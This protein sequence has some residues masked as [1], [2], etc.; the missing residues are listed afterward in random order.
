MQ[1]W[2]IARL[3]AQR[4]ARAEGADRAVHEPRVALPELGA[5]E[6][7]PLCRSRPEA[8]DERIGAVG[9]LEHDLAAPIG[10]EVDGERALAGVRGEE[11]RAFSV[12]K[13]RPPGAGVVPGKRLHLDDVGPERGEQLCRSRARE[14]GR[15]VDDLGAD[16]GT[17]LAHRSRE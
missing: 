9:E 3:A 14:R 6:A 1:Q 8:L 4:A 15:D 16:E 13:R 5:A 17:E 12:E 2:V 11:H 10:S 7:V